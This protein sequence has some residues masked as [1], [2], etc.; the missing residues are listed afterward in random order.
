MW[1]ITFYIAPSMAAFEAVGFED[2]SAAI[3]A[4]SSDI[5]F[6]DEDGNNI[7]I[8]ASVRDSSIVK[9]HPSSI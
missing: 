2:E 7:R 6:Q 5:W 8:P 1:S 3:V 9:I 4:L